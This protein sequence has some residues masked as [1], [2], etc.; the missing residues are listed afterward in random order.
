[1]R[2]ISPHVQRWLRQQGSRWGALR[3]KARYDPDAPFVVVDRD[4]LEECIRFLHRQ[5]ARELARDANGRVV[6]VFPDGTTEW[7]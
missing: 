6:Q 1:M 5:P 4:T 2:R 3:R 7:A